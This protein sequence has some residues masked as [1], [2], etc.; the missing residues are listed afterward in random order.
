M[1]LNKNNEVV[2]PQANWGN[3]NF[4]LIFFKWLAVSTYP[5]NPDPSK[6]WRHFEGLCVHPCDSYRFIHPWRVPSEDSWGRPTSLRPLVERQLWP[7]ERPIRFAAGSNFF[8]DER[9]K[10]T[11]RDHHPSKWMCKWY[12]I[13]ITMVDRK[14][15]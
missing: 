7:A 2:N 3:F 14:F 12:M 11:W 4:R 13:D 8:S 10:A 6:K 9:P 1:V 15:P 5:K